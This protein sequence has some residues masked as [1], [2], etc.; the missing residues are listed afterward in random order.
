MEMLNGKL[1]KE[2]AEAKIMI[3]RS[4]QDLEKERKARQLMEDVCD[5]LASEIGEEKSQ[6]EELKWESIKVREEVE[7]EQKMLQ[8]PE[9]LHQRTTRIL[10][11]TFHITTRILYNTFYITTKLKTL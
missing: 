9:V 2:L 11:S 10:Y 3:M 4:L 6:V 1:A 5:E 7:E 8:M